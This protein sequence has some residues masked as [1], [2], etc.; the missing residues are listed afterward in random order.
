VRNLYTVIYLVIWI[1][2]IVGMD[3]LFFRDRFGPRLIA[4]VAA[5]AVFA[6]FYLIFLKNR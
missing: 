4:N 3:V 5:V 1:S 6:A 2:V